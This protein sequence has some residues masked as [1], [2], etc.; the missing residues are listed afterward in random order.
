MPKATSQTRRRKVTALKWFKPYEIKGLDFVFA[1]RL[2]NAREKAGVPFYITSGFRTPEENEAIGGSKN[3]AHMIGQAVDIDVKDSI[4][5]FYIV[6]GLVEAGF[7]R[8]G[9][10]TKH[11]HADTDETKPQDVLWTGVSK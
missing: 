3:S 8:I 10:Y 1:I 9:V 4:H 11:I 7:N 5:R 2:D 6:K